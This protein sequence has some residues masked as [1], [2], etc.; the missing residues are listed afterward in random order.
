MIEVSDAWKEAHKRPF[1]PETFVE[2]SCEVTDVDGQELAE[3]T[4]ANESEISQIAYVRDQLGTSGNKRY[5]LE[6]N[7]ILLDGSFNPVIS[8]GS[9]PIE[10]C[11]S[12]EIGTEASVTFA[13]PGT[14]T[15]VIPGLT[16]TWSSL[17]GGYPL[18]FSVLAKNG[19]TEVANILVENNKSVVSVVDHILTGYDSIT[20]TA[21][22]WY[23]PDQRVRIEDI[24]LGHVVTFEK[25][26]LLSYTNEQHGD[27]NSAEIPKK[28]IE[29]SV[30]NSDGRWDLN[31]PQG[32]G[33]YLS[34]RQ[35]INVRYGM[36]I[37]GS[38]E[39]VHAGTYYL[40]GWDAPSNGIAATFTARDVFEYLMNKPFPATEISPLHLLIQKTMEVGGIQPRTS[41]VGNPARDYAAIIDKEY[42]CAE[43]IQMCANACGCVVIPSRERTSKNGGI[44][45]DP[46]NQ[47][48]SDYRIG[49]DVQY[50]YPEISLSKPLKSVLVSYGSEQ[51]YELSVSASG[52]TQTVNN[53]LV[54]NEAQAAMIAEWVK[55]MLESRKT[56]KGYFRADPRL[57]L[58]DVVQADSKYG[59]LAPLVITQIKYTYN[60]AF[61]ATYTGKVITAP[62]AQLGTFIL[63]A[64]ALGQGG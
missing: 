4:G 28:S 42:S 41:W 32:M 18:S 11:Y 27:I 29:F 20:V 31:N 61:N 15:A 3:I 24:A 56:V 16:I 37:N 9:Y 22:E 17:Y 36:D 35:R 5:S 47:A 50:S 43:V 10:G 21:H 6:R 8:A 38:V 25:G 62:T 54:M 63:G 60:G 57:E 30:D 23:L 59:L 45:V 46:L 52:E 13:F 19:E 55:K 34:E 40:S 2:I 48:M 1:V 39:W 26:D 49:A 64:T 44:D 58:F 53:P 12:N 7:F 14:R 51:S 33:R